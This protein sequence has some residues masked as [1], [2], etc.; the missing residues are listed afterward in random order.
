[1]KKVFYLCGIALILCLLLTSCVSASDSLTVDPGTSNPVPSDPKPQPQPVEEIPE[2]EYRDVVY[3]STLNSGTRGSGGHD[4]VVTSSSLVIDLETLKSRY[5]CGEEGCGHTKDSCPAYILRTG[6]TV[7]LSSDSTPDNVIGYISD[8][9]RGQIYRLDFS[10]GEKTVLCDKLPKDGFSFGIDPMTDNIFITLSVVGDDEQI[11]HYLYVVNG[12]TGQLR[13]LDTLD[14]GLRARYVIGDVVYCSDYL[15]DGSY[16]VDLS[17]E[18]LALKETRLE[19]EYIC[20]GYRYYRENVVEE[21]VSVP[22]D[23]ISLCEAYGKEAYREFTKYDLYRV[24]VLQKDAAPEFV[25]ANV[26][27]SGRNADYVYYYEFAPEHV[28]SY[29][30]YYFQ[31]EKNVRHYESYT[32]DAANVPEGV[33]LVNEFNGYYAPI[34]IL[35]AKTLK[36]V[37]VIDSEEYWIDPTSDLRLAGDGVFVT[38]QSRDEQVYVE[39]LTTGRKK[40]TFGYISFAKPNLTDED[41]RVIQESYFGR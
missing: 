36:E 16:R 38:W 30:M 6:N 20:G 11:E 35:D 21:R 31:D 13:T 10:T 2:G 12:K 24:N 37:A 29:Y 1:M 7:L 4:L 22:D 33:G 18:S 5:A 40:I 27:A 3:T 23:L 32:L 39:R 41:T 28:V 17:Q 34:H 14:A 9:N 8:T 19:T 15:G 26:I 25:A